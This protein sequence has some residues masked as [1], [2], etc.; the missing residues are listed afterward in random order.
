M[1]PNSPL[2][3]KASQLAHLVYKK[4]RAF[5]KEEIFGLTSQLRRAI[6]SVPLNI[7][8]GYARKGSNEYKRFLTIAYAS[9]Q[10][11]KYIL[12]F[13]RDEQYLKKEDFD[14]CFALAEEV[15]GMLWSSI[16]TLTSNQSIR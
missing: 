16:G 1:M 2:Y 3:R 14:E 6:L 15:G 10:E 5:P 8:E 4:V 11:S 7:V 9:L 12:E 13:A